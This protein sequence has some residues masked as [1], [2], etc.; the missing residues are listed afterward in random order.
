MIV[1]LLESTNGDFKNQSLKKQ[2]YFE[3]LKTLYS[4]P[5]PTL[6]AEKISH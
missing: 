6:S 1:L 3:E 5:E 4:D 2:K